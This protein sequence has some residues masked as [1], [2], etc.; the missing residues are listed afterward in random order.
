MTIQQTPQAV[1]AIVIG[2]GFGGIFAVHKMANEHNLS[3]IGFDKA[4]GPGG[5]W[6]WNRYPGAQSDTESHFYR[7]SFDK[8]MLQEDTWE[9]NYVTQPEI[10]EYAEGV[11][12]RFDLWQH[13]RFSTEVTS[14][15]YLEDVQLW[16]ITAGGDLYRAR[17]VI[18]GLGL[19]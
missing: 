9:N 18:N 12:D 11:L 3:V 13:F 4:G 10:L 8:E 17:Y 15:M 16:E 19:L 6:Y 1:D 14:A 7:Y 2:A 5:T